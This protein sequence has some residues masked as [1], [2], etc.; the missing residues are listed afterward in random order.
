MRTRIA[1]LAVV[2]TTLAFVPT[3]AATPTHETEWRRCR[4]KPPDGAGW[5]DVRA[6][7]VSCKDARAVARKYW[8]NGG[9][10]HV[11]VDGVTY[12]CKDEPIGEE[13]SRARC[14]AAQERRVRFKYGA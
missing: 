10:D 3:A 2:F 8:N 5:Y 13:V 1:F 9:P 7:H 12:H 4:S 11:R 6:K 14:R